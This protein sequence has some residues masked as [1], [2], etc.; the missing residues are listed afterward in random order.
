M[1]M[2]YLSILRFAATAGALLWCLKDAVII[3][4]L[5]ST[6]EEPCFSLT[7]SIPNSDFSS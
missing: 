2:L 6:V 4:M 1:K 3:R 5:M 7:F